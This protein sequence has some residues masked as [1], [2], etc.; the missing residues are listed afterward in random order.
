M[1]FD[2]DDRDVMREA[3]DLPVAHGPTKWLLRRS[4][5][6]NTDSEIQSF[7]TLCSSSGSPGIT[8]LECSAYVV[9]RAGALQPLR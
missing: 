5:E 7:Q 2:G 1:R 4:D 9:W 6:S 8:E 3:G